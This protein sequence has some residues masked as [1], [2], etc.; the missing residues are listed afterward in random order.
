MWSPAD[1]PD[2]EIWR[3]ALEHDA[4]I[5]T[6]DEDFRR[7]GRHRSGGTVSWRHEPDVSSGVGSTVDSSGLDRGLVAS[8]A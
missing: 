1:A 5:V 7:L 6:K 8:S 2:S 3:Y 4:V